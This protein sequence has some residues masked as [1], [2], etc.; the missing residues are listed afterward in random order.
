[1]LFLWLSVDIVFYG[2]GFGLNELGGDLYTNGI[3]FGIT[4]V[5]SAL[6]ISQLVNLIGRK[7]SLLL[8]WGSAAVGSI[9]YDFVRNYQT[10]S[11]IALIFS[12]FGGAGTFQIMYLYTSEAFPSEVRGTVLGLSNAMA[13]VGGLVAPLFSS[14]IDHFM[15]IFGALAALS[16]V[17]SLFLRET[18][19]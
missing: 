17:A 8:T 2:V 11:Y 15:L 14:Y 12:R 1:M 19:G 9:V 4:D 5:V 16:F 13:S 3:L 18:K 7:P 10:A 6:I